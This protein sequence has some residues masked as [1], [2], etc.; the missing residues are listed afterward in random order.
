[1]K[2]KWKYW[3]GHLILDQ[4][5]QGYPGPGANGPCIDRPVHKPGSTMPVSD[6]KHW[7]MLTTDI[8]QVEWY[9]A[10]FKAS[11]RHQSP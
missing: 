5:S 8:K 2:V 1:M 6:R 3:V 4:G 7:G 9:V 10:Q 11:V